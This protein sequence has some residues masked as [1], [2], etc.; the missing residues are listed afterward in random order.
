MFKA[1]KSQSPRTRRSSPPS[2]RRGVRRLAGKKRRRRGP[3]TILILPLA[4]VGVAVM[5][6]VKRAFAGDFEGAAKELV[7]TATGV[8]TEDGSF[9]PEWL[10]KFWMPIIVGAVGHKVAG[11]VGINRMFSRL[12]SPLNKLR[13]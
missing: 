6:P 13:L 9:H 12:P 2:R 1:G 5:E 4:G 11:M 7:Q 10:Q 3:R 8:S